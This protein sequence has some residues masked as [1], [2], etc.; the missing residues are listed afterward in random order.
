MQIRLKPYHKNLYQVNSLL[1]T[2]ETAQEW[3]SAICQLHIDLQQVETY[4]VPGVKANSLYGCVLFFDGMPLPKDIRNHHYLQ[5]AENKLLMPEQSIYLPAVDEEELKSLSP[6]K[7]IL[8]HPVVGC[9]VLDEPVDWVALLGFDEAASIVPHKPVSGVKIPGSVNAYTLELSDEKLIADLLNPPSEK[10]IIDNLPFD[11][12]KLMKG[13]KREMEKYLKYL[14]AHPDKALSM[15]LPLD[16]LGS[17]RGDNKGRFSFSGS[18][19]QRLFNGSGHQPTRG[20]NTGSSGTGNFWWIGIAVVSVIKIM[21]CNSGTHEKFDTTQIK[22][23]VVVKHQSVLDSHYSR[24]MAL[25]NIVLLNKL[26]SQ[27]NTSGKVAETYISEQKKINESGGKIKDSLTDIYLAITRRKTDSAVKAWKKIAADSIKKI[28]GKANFQKQLQEATKLKREKTYRDY[29][30][31]YGVVED[32]TVLRYMPEKEMQPTRDEQAGRNKMGN[33]GYIL[34]LT[35]ALI[36]VALLF[37]QL[38]APETEKG[39]ISAGQGEMP[40]I[41]ILLL[42]IIMTVSIIYILQP[43]LETYGFGWLSV[44]VCILLLLLLYRLFGKGLTILNS[45][46]KK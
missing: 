30:I 46:N 18:W 28:A 10:E 20:N 24:I 21:T 4:A 34:L 39:K 17:F 2:G 35:V 14:E 25:K 8:L 9:V 38:Q 13:N 29:A 6:G 26:K 5:Y 40:W 32:S 22:D 37:V 42:M 36:G 44:G 15:A 12:K 43:L 7:K 31:Y 16:V 19:M 23:A 1:I 27:N 3:I 45:D 33:T 11:V 41:R